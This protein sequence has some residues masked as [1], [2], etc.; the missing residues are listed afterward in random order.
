[1]DATGATKQAPAGGTLERGAADREPWDRRLDW[2]ILFALNMVVPALIASMAIRPIGWIGVIAAALTLGGIGWL[3]LGRSS[4][5]C[6]TA[7]VGAAETAATQLVPLLQ[8]WAGASALWLLATNFS[9]AESPSLGVE[10]AFIATIVT[11]GELLL[12]SLILGVASRGLVALIRLVPPKR[13]R[14]KATK[15]STPDPLAEPGY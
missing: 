13:D 2:A 8:L 10:G 14:P 15:G 1:M 11:G 6:R 12:V 9:E 7:I 3:V 4:W 5:W